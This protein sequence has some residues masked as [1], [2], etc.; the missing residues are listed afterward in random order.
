MALPARAPTARSLI[1]SLQIGGW[2]E[3]EAG[4]LVAVLHGLRPSRNGWSV[5]EIEHL[6]WV[7]AQVESG[8]LTS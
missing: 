5:R 1:W 4:N 8:R 3:L 2:S 7:R 6:R